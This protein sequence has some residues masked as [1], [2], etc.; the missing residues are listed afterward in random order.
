MTGKEKRKKRKERKKQQRGALLLCC[1]AVLADTGVGVRDVA[2][3][4]AGSKRFARGVAPGAGEAI[5]WAS[6]SEIDAGSEGGK[7]V[8]VREHVVHNHHV[9]GIKIRQV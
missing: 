8:A 1:V 6:K 4:F 2:W 3:E 9:C 7:G 5:I